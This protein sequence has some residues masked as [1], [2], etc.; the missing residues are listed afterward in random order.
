M[1]S[2][3]YNRFVGIHRDRRRILL[4]LFYS[5]ISGFQASGMMNSICI[6][7]CSVQ[8]NSV[9]IKICVLRKVI[10]MIQ[11]IHGQWVAWDDKKDIDNRHKHG[12]GFDIAAEV[13]RDNKRIE[14]YDAKHSSLQE[15]RYIILGLVHDVLFVVYTQRGNVARLI[16]ARIADRKEKKIYYGNETKIYS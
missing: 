2:I 3:L 15:D 8:I 10:Y 6:Y 12:I 13:F 14:I 4:R 9:V 1:F 5:L 11:W 16:S 7:L